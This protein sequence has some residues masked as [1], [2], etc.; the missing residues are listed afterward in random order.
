LFLHN[1][2]DRPCQVPFGL[3]AEQPGRPLAVVA[4]SD[5]GEKLDLDAIELA[6]YG[7]R[8]I[9]LRKHP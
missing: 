6:A 7:Y 9:R 1:L 5:Y 3:Q 8:W 2:A 4:D